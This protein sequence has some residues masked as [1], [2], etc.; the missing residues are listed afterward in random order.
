MKYFLL[1]ITIF[2][3]Y[4]SNA[5]LN[6]E[7]EKS[8]NFRTYNNLKNIEGKT[9]KSNVLFRSGSISSLM[10]S[11]KEKMA[12][13]KLNKI[14][15]FRT[16]YEVS[17]ELD[18]TAGLS[19]QTI[20]IPIGNITKES[21]LTMFSVLNNPN[22]SENTVDS[23]M[24]SF[25]KNFSESI[26][27]YKSFFRV[28]LEPNS[29]VLF[30]CSAGKDRT[31]IASALLLKALDFDD[32]TILDDFM[33]SNDAVRGVDLDKMKMYGIPEKY[34]Q[35]L[36]KVKPEYLKEAISIINFK[37]G[38]LEKM[39]DTELGIG[40]NEKKFLKAKYLN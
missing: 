25:Y 4:V 37:Y 12:K 35:I 28:L 30:H 1:L 24:L 6:M 34:A 17:R 20:R 14:V 2:G 27:S 13:L 22:S 32:D 3:F 5:Q 21:S 26:H 19:V 15:D 18:D 16:D 7:I 39:M 38:S 9:F 29:N 36:M 10:S 40:A 8:P 31:G 11:D 23:M 33:R